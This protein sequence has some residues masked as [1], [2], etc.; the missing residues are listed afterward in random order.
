MS[1]T[2]SKAKTAKKASSKAKEKT[3]SKELVTRKQIS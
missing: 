2:E 1:V 3:V